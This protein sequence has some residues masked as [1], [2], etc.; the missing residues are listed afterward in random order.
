MA[1]GRK[2]AKK[3]EVKYAHLFKK[4]P[5][6]FRIGRD[7][8]P[9]QNLSRFVKWPKYIRIQRQKAILKKRLKVP[10]AIQQFTQT[11]DKNQA[12]TLFKLL[13]KYRPET[14]KEKKERLA[15]IADAKVKNE[16]AAKKDKPKV[17]KYGLN[18]ITSLVESRKASLVI[19]AHDVDPIELVVWLPTL[20]RRM[21]VPFCIVKGKAR[22]GALCH[23]KTATAVALTGV[24]KQDE[25]ALQQF[26]ASVSGMY[27][28][29]YRTWGQP[30]LGV[31]A[32][33]KVRA[34]QREIEK[35]KA[36]RF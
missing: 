11:I 8:Q 36:K 10:P 25:R 35:E 32:M 14:K 22:L 17:L 29:P 26:V 9:T 21:Q 19:I 18:H 2:T 30:E 27:E 1:K 12:M 13:S 4:T 16:K 23:M 3:P 24:D 5:R 15:Q 34:R 6:D 33:H 28:E 20:C 31:K 7:I